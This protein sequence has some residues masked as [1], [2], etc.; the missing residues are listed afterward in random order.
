VA[1]QA[2]RAAREVAA[3]PL[4]AS[5]AAVAQPAAQVSVAA[6]VGGVVVEA[7][8]PVV[9]AGDGGRKVSGFKFRVSG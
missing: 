5:A 1:A 6:P 3:V 8:E 4:R 2:N 7:R 9:V